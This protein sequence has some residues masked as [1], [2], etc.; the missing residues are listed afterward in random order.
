LTKVK[1]FAIGNGQ[2]FTLRQWIYNE[3]KVGIC[4]PS[5]Q[6]L[7]DEGDSVEGTQQWQL[8]RTCELALFGQD[9]CTLGETEVVETWSSDCEVE[10]PVCEEP[11]PTPTVEPTPTEVPPVVQQSVNNNP[12]APSCTEAIVS[13]EAINFHIFRKGDQAIAKWWATGGNKAT[14]YYKQV[15][16]PDWQYSLVVD[17]TGYAEIN[18]LGSLDITF[19][20]QQHN[21]C[22]TGTLTT[23]VIDG[24]SEGW[25]LFR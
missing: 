6:C 16:S 25:I 3:E 15:G 19:A 23:P 4:V 11:T 20:L 24:A 8:T 13:K 1:V 2:D 18:G 22:G 10:V 12:E 5:V 21:N 7:E 17:N 9:R 14:I